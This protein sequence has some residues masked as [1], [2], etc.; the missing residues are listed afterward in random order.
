MKL[1]MKILREIIAMKKKLKLKDKIKWVSFDLNFHA[2]T[3][4]QK[5][6]IWIFAPKKINSFLRQNVLN[7]HAKKYQIDIF[8]KS[9][10]FEFSRQ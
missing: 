5:I 9:K 1:R 3:W 6:P 8:L 10:Y 7:F 2:K 4:F